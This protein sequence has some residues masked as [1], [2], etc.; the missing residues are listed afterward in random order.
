M[1][2][3]TAKTATR[4]GDSTAD[5]L[6]MAALHLFDRDG[7]DA[8]TIDDIAAAANVS[9]RT[10]FRHFPRKE[11]VILLE[12]SVIHAEFRARF[13]KRRPG[14]S[15]LDEFIAG[16][17]SL[18]RAAAR[19]P[20]RLKL[21]VKL[22]R[23]VPELAWTERDADGVTIE[24]FA[25]AYSAELGGRPADRVR[26]FA[27]GSAVVAAANAAL[28]E[29]VEGGDA[30][31]LFNA[32]AASIRGWAPAA[33]TRPAVAVVQV[34]AGLSDEDAADLIRE[35]LAPSQAAG[36]RKTAGRRPHAG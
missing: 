25:A 8:T 11:A 18:L 36:G 14:V 13:E 5:R 23:T 21:R 7:F 10:F 34:P 29:S 17:P 1:S 31:A 26:A 20:E 3:Q 33:P 30:L 16:V 32:A 2:D 35:A 12:Q 6:A 22:I 28:A 4:E 27:V 9:R 24:M 19:D 15:V